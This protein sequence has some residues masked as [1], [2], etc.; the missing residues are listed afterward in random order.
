MLDDF[1][2]AFAHHDVIVNDQH[3]TLARLRITSVRSLHRS[4]ENVQI[5][6]APLP[7]ADWTC[8]PAS[9]IPAR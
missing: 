1:G 5:I 9:I 2:D 4:G 8:K 7:G 3:A 6:F